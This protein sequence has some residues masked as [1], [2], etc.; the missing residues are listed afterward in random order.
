MN[1]IEGV[2]VAVGKGVIVD[3]KVWVRKKGRVGNLGGVCVIGAVGGY[4]V[5][6]LD[7]VC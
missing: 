6:G 4:S 2:P 5:D 1:G 7:G 3:A